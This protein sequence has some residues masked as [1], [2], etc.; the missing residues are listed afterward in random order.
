VLQLHWLTAA[1]VLRGAT[2]AGE[3]ENALNWGE[4]VSLDKNKEKLREVTVK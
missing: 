1:A 3:V 2:A 4:S